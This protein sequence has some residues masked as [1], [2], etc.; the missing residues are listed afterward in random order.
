MVSLPSRRAFLAAIPAATVVTAARLPASI[1]HRV[2][3]PPGDRKRLTLPL[4]SPGYRM[5][6]RV[7]TNSWSWSPY[8]AV[9]TSW[10]SGP[11]Q[12]WV[13]CGSP[14]HGGQRYAG[15]GPVQGSPLT[16]SLSSDDHEH[17]MTVA[18]SATA[19]PGR[20]ARHDWRQVSSLPMGVYPL[21]DSDV[22]AGRII[23]V[24]TGSMEPGL[25]GTWYMPLFA[26]GVNVTAT[27]DDH[28]GRVLVTSLDPALRG[29]GQGILCD[30]AIP[31][32]ARVRF[33][34]GLT[35]SPSLLTVWNTSQRYS[36]YEV[37]V[38]IGGP[39]AGALP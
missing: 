5:T 17:P 16:M 9:T 26:G 36:R 1:T 8:C 11:S 22:P 39:A 18:V 6:A 20:F 29:P 15:T 13:L 28:A 38:R 12:R 25:L 34:L 30:R 23:Q 35:R 10:P 27:S 4:A 32:G 37:S 7:L 21:G 3:L 2:I 14:D 31:A 24:A 33:H 19:D